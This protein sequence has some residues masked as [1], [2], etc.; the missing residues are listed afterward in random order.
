[1]SRSQDLTERPPDAKVM[2]RWTGARR[3][4]TGTHCYYCDGAIADIA[5]GGCGS[6]EFQ[7]QDRASELC[8]VYQ[9]IRRRG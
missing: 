6:K 3:L 4:T 8:E 5:Q 9:Q 2:V 7:P 1:M